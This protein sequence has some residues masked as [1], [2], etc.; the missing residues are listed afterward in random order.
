VFRIFLQYYDSDGR[1]SVETIRKYRIILGALWL[2]LGS[3]V[4]LNSLIYFVHSLVSGFV[5]LGTNAGSL[6]SSMDLY[7]GN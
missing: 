4:Y 7:S 2:P 3:L 1:I 5:D 6:F